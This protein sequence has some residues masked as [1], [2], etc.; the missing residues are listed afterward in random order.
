MVDYYMG[1]KIEYNPE[2][3][4][5]Q[6][7]TELA[8]IQSDI[9]LPDDFFSN[10]MG[11][12]TPEAVEEKI[13]NKEAN[14][15]KKNNQ[16]KISAFFNGEKIQIGRDSSNKRPLSPE[17]HAFKQQIEDLFE[18]LEL[19]NVSEK[20]GVTRIYQTDS[21]PYRPWRFH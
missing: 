16:P 14:T 20:V 13:Q 11:K 17:E 18:L 19:E 12:R 8:N 9:I 6:D 5:F 3:W 1:Q 7:G 2:D 21:S 4:N 15:N 10:V